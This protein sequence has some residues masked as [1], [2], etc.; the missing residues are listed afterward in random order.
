MHKENEMKAKS[1]KEVLIAA[2]WIID[3]IGWCQKSYYQT[4]SGERRFDIEHSYGDVG[5]VCSVGAIGFV[6]TDN[7]LRDKACDFL[8]GV[9]GNLDGIP[10]WNDKPERTK[11]EV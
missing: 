3:N 10:T 7:K 6:E 8:E 4:K 1:V 5:S 2:R 9:L 11:E